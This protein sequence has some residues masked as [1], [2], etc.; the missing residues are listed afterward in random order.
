MLGAFGQRAIALLD[1]LAARIRARWGA[2]SFCER[3]NRQIVIAIQ[4][5]NAVCILE[6]HSGLR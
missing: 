5:E 4:F 3:L 6:V 1:E 2:T